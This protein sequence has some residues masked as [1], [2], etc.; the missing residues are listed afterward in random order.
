MPRKKRGDN[1]EKT[2]ITTQEAGRKGGITVKERYGS[3]FYSE[4]GKKG[5]QKGGKKGGQTTQAK[6]KA[7]LTISGNV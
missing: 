6:V 5:G 1:R 3:E 2:A 7:Y 4:I